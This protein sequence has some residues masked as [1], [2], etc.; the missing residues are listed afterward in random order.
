MR[1]DSIA[2]PGGVKSGLGHT[3]G[4]KAALH[5]FDFVLCPQAVVEAL[6]T[7]VRVGAE[8]AHIEAIATAHP[9]STST[10]ILG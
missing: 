5:S 1:S 7:Q 8:L 9:V 3:T 6:S 4:A 2:T 10:R